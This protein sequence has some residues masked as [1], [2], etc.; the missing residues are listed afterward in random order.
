MTPLQIVL[1][2]YDTD[3]ILDF[4]TFLSKERESLLLLESEMLE[5]RSNDKIVETVISKLRDRSKIGI[6]KYGVTLERK[7]INFDGWLNHLQEELF[8]ASL[9]IERL[10]N[11]TK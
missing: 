9:Y 8:D 2:R 1:K 11:E 6:K 10:K 3:S 5:N 4:M 7:D